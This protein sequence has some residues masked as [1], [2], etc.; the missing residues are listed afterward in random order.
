MKLEYSQQRFEKTSNI[1]FHENLSSGSRHVP[2][3]LE[4][5][6]EDKSNSATRNSTSYSLFLKSGRL[7]STVSTYVI[8]VC[9]ILHAHVMQCYKSHFRC[10][11]CL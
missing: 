3:N 6:R 10:M 11:L 4:I 8:I 9:V 2:I 1:K 5:D 7:C